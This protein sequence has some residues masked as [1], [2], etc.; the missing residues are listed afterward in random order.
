MSLFYAVQERESRKYL[1]STTPNSATFVSERRQAMRFDE[2]TEADRVALSLAIAADVVV[3]S[4][5]G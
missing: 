4:T 5:E 1:V 3:L 2:R